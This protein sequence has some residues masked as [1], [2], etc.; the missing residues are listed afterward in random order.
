MFS[1][2][3]SRRPVHVGKFIN[4]KKSDCRNLPAPEQKID[5]ETRQKKYIK[6]RPPS[7]L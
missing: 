1:P 4:V 7:F 3:D 5:K 2:R 6:N